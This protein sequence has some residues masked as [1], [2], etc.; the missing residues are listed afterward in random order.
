[1]VSK[2][3]LTL[4]SLG[5]FLKKHIKLGISALKKLTCRLIWNIHHYSHG[6]D[7]G[8]LPKGDAI[9]QPASDRY[10][11]A[12]ELFPTTKWHPTSMDCELGRG[13]PKKQRNVGTFQWIILV[14]VG[15]VDPGL[16][17]TPKRRPIEGHVFLKREHTTFLSAYG[18]FLVYHHLQQ[19]PFN[20]NKSNKSN[21]Y[22]T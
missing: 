12:L 8:I 10:M 6:I 16:L 18:M 19:H 22:S 14:L 7:N 11:G 20:S 15:R 13:P 1:M 17:I 4:L 9:F 21:V 5:N 2:M 3:S